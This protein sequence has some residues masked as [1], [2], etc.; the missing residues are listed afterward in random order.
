MVDT[1]K[2][3]TDLMDKK[4]ASEFG[5]LAR[6]FVQ[7]GGSVVSMAHVNK[8]KDGE[9][10]SVRAGTSDIQDDADCTYIMEIINQS[11]D[12]K[13]VQFRNEKARGDVV[14]EATYR[15]TRITGET[16]FDLL[17]SVESVDK[18]QADKES[19][20]Y[21]RQQQAEQNREA[22]DEVVA[23]IRG[24]ITLKT[25]L[26]KEVSARTAI[27]KNKISKV[28]RQFNGNRP[29]QYWTARTGD[30]NSQIYELNKQTKL[31]GPV[32]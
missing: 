28:L 2:K 24:G 10:K 7:A 5:N 31:V 18:D 14:Q 17:G 13:T 3:F 30:H 4:T 15:Y 29:Y 11:G 23:C 20:D 21:Q 8:H 19:L 16:Y 9:G 1:L 25:D 12:T 22:I 6:Q 32:Y 27:G 26:M